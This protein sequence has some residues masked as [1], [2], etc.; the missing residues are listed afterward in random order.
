MS[1]IF[2][3]L[4]LHQIVIFLKNINKFEEFQS[5]YKSGHSTETALVMVQ[6]QILTE[7]DNGNVVI[8]LMLDMSAAFAVDHQLLLNRLEKVYGIS[9]KV[10]KWFK[11]YLV[12]RKQMVQIGESKSDEANLSSGVP[13]GSILGPL[14]FSLHTQ[15]LCRLLK[16]LGLSYQLSYLCR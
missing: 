3:K 5:A 9:G 15:P 11:T 2:E 1:K 4:A 13:Q 12:D 7:I 16:R 10:L 8:L 6:N 14:L